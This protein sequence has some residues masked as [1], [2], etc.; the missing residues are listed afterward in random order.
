MINAI[1]ATACKG[2]V[3]VVHRHCLRRTSVQTRKVVSGSRPLLR[4][5]DVEVGFG[6]FDDLIGD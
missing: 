6:G 5:H 3:N 1:E 4:L 2:Q